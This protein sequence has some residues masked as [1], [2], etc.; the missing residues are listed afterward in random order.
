MSQATTG[1]KIRQVVQRHTCEALLGGAAQALCF[2]VGPFDVLPSLVFIV[3][4]G[5]VELDLRLDACTVC[6][7]APQTYL[8][9][10]FPE[11]VTHQPGHFQHLQ[12][13]EGG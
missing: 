9:T 2:A 8:L 11:N 13:R 6:R 1:A 5:L 7:H 4:E 12:V 10:C 3:A